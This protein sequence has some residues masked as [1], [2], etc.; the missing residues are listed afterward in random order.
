M[1]HLITTQDSM[2]NIISPM[3]AFIVIYSF[4]INIKD[5]H[6]KKTRKGLLF[7]FN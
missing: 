4:N 1:P 2:I 6:K 3:V 7:I 5:V